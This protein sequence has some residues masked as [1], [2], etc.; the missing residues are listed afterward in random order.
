M[1]RDRR[2]ERY[3]EGES[4]YFSLVE[5]GLGEQVAARVEELV[6]GPPE[7]FTA[8]AEDLLARSSALTPLARSALQH[9]AG[10][11]YLR[12]GDGDRWSHLDRARAHLLSAVRCRA[13]RRFPRAVGE[14][15]QHL[16]QVV[17]SLANCADEVTEAWRLRERA[18]SHLDEARRAFERIGWPAGYL[19]A[20][21]LMNLGSLA[22]DC[23]KYERAS[24]LYRRAAEIWQ[25][26]Y[27]RTPYDLAVAE[28][29][30]LLGLIW[31]N[32]LTARL[33]TGG[34][35]ARVRE[36]LRERLRDLD[37]PRLHLVGL[38]LPDLSEEDAEV[39]LRQVLDNLSDFLAEPETV[40][41]V[42]A[43]ACS[44]PLTAA[45]ER[46]LW[47][48]VEGLVQVRIGTYGGVRADEVT[49]QLQ[50][51]VR[52]WAR[53]Q[54][55]TNPVE[56][57]CN[58]ERNSGLRLQET[59]RVMGWVPPTAELRAVLGR[60]IELGTMSRVVDDMGQ[61]LAHL[62]P[63][64]A[65]E[66]VERWEQRLSDTPRFDIDEPILDD[67]SEAGLAAL[68]R[69]WRLLD[70]ELPRAQALLQ[71]ARALDEDAT[72][73]R[74]QLES[75]PSWLEARDRV[76]MPM[77][78]ELLE[79]LLRAYPNTAFMRLEQV[80]DVLV[81]VFVCLEERGITGYAAE[82]EWAAALGGVDLDQLWTTGALDADAMDAMERLDLTSW[83][84]VDLAPRRLVILPGRG[85]AFLP[86]LAAGPRGRTLLDRFE[87]V[88]FLWGL[89]PLRARVVDR[90]PRSGVLEIA[91]G[92]ELATVDPH[93][94][95]YAAIALSVGLPGERPVRCSGREAAV[96][97]WSHAQ[98]VSIL[99]HGAHVP[100]DE[101]RPL[102]GT[103]LLLGPGELLTPDHVVDRTQG[104]ERVE[105][106]ACQSG[107]DLPLDPLLPVHN[108]GAGFD[109]ELLAAG[110]RT[111][112][113]TLWS[114][115]QL[116]SAFICLQF[117]L[118]CVAGD[119]AAV[120][121]A[122]AQRWWRDEARA[123]LQV[124]LDAG[125]SAGEAVVALWGAL[126]GEAPAEP[127]AARIRAH[128][129]ARGAAA[130]IEHTLDPPLAHA[131]FRFSGVPNR[132]VEAVWDPPLYP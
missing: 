71:R 27:R 12:R 10:V 127:D 47:G 64:G 112:I 132:P 1:P 3:L 124:R 111:T 40:R 83:L 122:S 108:E 26:R 90:V 89:A 48:L 85:A 49:A 103:H 31:A 86:L 126:L 25:R 69:Q 43:V 118:R 101:D 129:D 44:R 63:S 56:A 92:L 81:A 39:H 91:P 73:L 52:L 119:D 96:Q 28:P 58:L 6:L 109:Y 65:A 93:A 123:G 54:A 72:V 16:G 55:R 100:W 115:E 66:A 50:Q 77:R 14:S 2:Y 113:A 5:Q 20:V 70:S 21:T 116:A 99:A 45:V 53:A 102:T 29:L 120:A 114:V 74:L 125:A 130:L 75:D 67:L 33:W 35:R 110:A 79:G 42:V 34:E 60:W 7:R 24:K 23:G 97:V 128:L 107:I 61:Q 8:F 121:L 15:W 36:D 62:S 22:M 98:V 117:R 68:R 37:H 11:A 9:Q 30:E 131:A 78:A 104:V 87:A 84:P 41:R 4:R 95:P 19:E 57:F 82:L 59:W 51:T 80:D 76:S 17:R 32:E 38:S 106:W 88:Q 18:E 105:F 13:R 46:V 94:T